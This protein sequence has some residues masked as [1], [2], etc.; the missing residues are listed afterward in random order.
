MQD[1]VLSDTT[2]NPDDPNITKKVEAF[3]ASK[4]EDMLIEAGWSSLN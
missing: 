2:L 1:I 3:C 4:V